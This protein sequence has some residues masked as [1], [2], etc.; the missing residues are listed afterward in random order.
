MHSH[1]L[2]PAAA[3]A[4]L[5]ILSGCGIGHQTLG[6]GSDQN[7][8]LGET[9]VAPSVFGYAVADEPQAALAGR[10]MLNN[11]GD[12]ADAAAAEGF[13]LSVTLPS[14]AGLGGGG[15]CI[16]KM[17]NAQGQMQPPVALLFPAGS[18]AGNG[19]SRPAAVPAMARGLLALQARYGDLPYASVI[20]PAEQLA[21]GS[22][23]SPALEADLQVVGRALLGDP[24]A[25]AV[26]GPNGTILPAGAN[27]VQPDLASTFE[28]LRTQGLQGFYAGTSAQQ[29][30]AAADQAGAGL[31]VAD[32]ADSTPKFVK[33]VISRAHGLT[34]AMLPTEAA[35]GQTLPASA[36]FMAL[37]KKGGVVACAVSINNLFGTGRIAPGTGVLLAASPRNVPAPQ[38]AAGIAYDDALTFRAAAAGTGQAAAAAAA[39]LAL[40]DAVSDGR[41]KVA[42]VPDPGRADVIACPGGV[43]GGE[44]SCTAS[45]D[46]RGQGLAI[47]GR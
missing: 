4:A 22:P 32:L 14:R 23:V 46:P 40:T 45:V 33:P 17:P 29:F 47:G 41:H 7:A 16:V 20:E 6:L 35:N 42:P 19:G 15:A 2:R 43:P 26:F 9:N 39:R 38:L 30:V 10:Q 8:A 44:G 13:A 1:I 25:A 34:L 11:G 37:D 12:A 28:V 24:A 3:L 5:G 31:T 27:L 36:A 21:A 18:P